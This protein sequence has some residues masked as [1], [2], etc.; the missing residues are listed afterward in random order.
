MA[1]M[2][3]SINLAAIPADATEILIYTDGQYAETAAEVKA[4]WPNATYH[5]ISPM[6]QVLAQWIDVEPGAVWP[7]QAAASLFHVWGRQGCKGYYSSLNNMQ[8][9]KEAH[10]A[11]NPGMSAEYFDANY[12][13]VEH[14]DPGY[15][16]TQYT[17]PGPYDISD[18][19]AQFEQ[20][21][22]P[23]SHSESSTMSVICG[24]NGPGGAV[25]W[26][27]FVVASDNNVYY[28]TGPNPTAMAQAPWTL[29]AIPGGTSAVT[30]SA[31][32]A[33]D[34]SA[35]VL[36]AQGVDNHAYIAVLPVPGGTWSAWMNKG[37]NLI[38]PTTGPAG[39]AGAT[40]P[41][42]VVGPAGPQGVAGVAGPAGPAGPQGPPGAQGNPGPLGPEGPAGT[43]TVSGTITGTIVPA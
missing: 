29:V 15:V 33:T 43:L 23:P 5:T 24:L 6:G 42:G 17:D 19:T 25:R 20:I 28:A 41:Q 27:T 18:T 30:V 14:V 3:D 21:T 1:V 8:A 9:L 37:G 2:Y 38:A 39:P 26:D 32:W 11:E 13:G 10:Q 16:A 35:L 40:G 12:T 31:A 22:Y 34:Y 7:N 36:E 4:R